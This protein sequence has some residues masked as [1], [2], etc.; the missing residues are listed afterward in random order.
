MGKQDIPVQKLDADVTLTNPFIYRISELYKLMQVDV[1]SEPHRLNFN[2]LI[3]ITEG[4]GIH[5]IEHKMY[6]LRPGTLLTVG[7]NQIHAFTRELSVEGYVLPF[8]AEMLNLNAQE[9]YADLMLAALNENN[10]V[11]DAGEAVDILFEQMVKEFESESEFQ[12]EIIRNLLRA[13]ILKSVVPNYKKE[14]NERAP[15]GQKDFYRIKNYIDEHFAERPTTSEI[16][17]ALN[18]SVKQINRLAKDNASCS[19][20]ELLDERV[21]TEAKRLLAY[22]QLS[23]VEV[24]HELGFNEATNMTKFFKRHTAIS[25]K[26]FRQLCK[27]GLNRK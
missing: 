9:S 2:A 13:I 10:V 19:T 23:I 4:E 24:A 5:Y 22:S 7:Q 25:P 21:L 18:K 8:N 1:V 16:A 11:Q 17:S 14:L 20:K 12:R 6:R 26:E 3:Y 27:V 15:A